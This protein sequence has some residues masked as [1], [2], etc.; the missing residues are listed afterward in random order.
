[1]QTVENLIRE[2]QL[3]LSRYPYYVRYETI[4]RGTHFVKLRLIIVKGLFVQINRNETTSLTN[5][6]L[7]QGTHRIYGRD[8]YRGNWHRHSASAPE[9]HDPSPEGSRP[10]T[11]TEFLVEVDALLHTRGLV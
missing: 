2:V 9:R 11:L 3:A 5:L 6:A 1:V 8:E 4:S 10:I 7:N